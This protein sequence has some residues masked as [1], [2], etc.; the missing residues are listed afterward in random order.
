MCESTEC[1]PSQCTREHKKNFLEVH[2]ADPGPTFSWVQADGAPDVFLGLRQRDVPTGSNA[3]RRVSEL[4][5]ESE[6]LQ[7]VGE[8]GEEKDEHEGGGK[9]RDH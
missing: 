2:V 5:P 4:Y 9:G 1:L 3:L 7:G 6:D 8:V